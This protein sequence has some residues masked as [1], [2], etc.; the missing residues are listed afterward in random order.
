LQVAQIAAHEVETHIGRALL[1]GD[2]REGAVIRVGARDG[3]LMVEY[4]GRAA[5][6]S[7]G[8]VGA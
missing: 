4:E 3:G 1:S 2:L 7:A 6:A 8:R 5:M